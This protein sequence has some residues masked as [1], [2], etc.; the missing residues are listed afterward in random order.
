MIEFITS[1]G[2]IYILSDLYLIRIFRVKLDSI[3][4]VFR[5][6][7]MFVLSGLFRTV[8][9]TVLFSNHPEVIID[10]EI[11]EDAKEKDKDEL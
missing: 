4:Q 10:A 8:S 5:G 2:I 9:L 11:I 1:L 3:L 7:K 6:L